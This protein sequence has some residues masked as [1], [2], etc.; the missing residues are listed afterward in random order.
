ME[1]YGLFLDKKAT[2][3]FQGVSLFGIVLV[4]KMNDWLNN[5]FLNYSSLQ[6]LSSIVVTRLK[7]FF[8]LPSGL[9][10]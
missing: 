2:E 10:G 6:I 5:A 3:L 7:L 9:L 1:G 8:I 4:S